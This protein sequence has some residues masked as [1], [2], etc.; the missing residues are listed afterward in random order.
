MLT[1]AGA[2]AAVSIFWEEAAER[3]A[4]ASY[5]ARRRLASKKPYNNPFW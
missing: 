5:G 3:P 1:S 4:Q 2:I